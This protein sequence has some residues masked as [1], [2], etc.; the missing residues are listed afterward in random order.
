MSYRPAPPPPLRAWVAHTPSKQ[1]PRFHLLTEHILRVAEM[2]R[3]F[4]EPFQA[5]EIAY[6]LGLLHDLGKFK[7]E[8]QQYL[9]DCYEAAKKGKSGP[10]P[11]TA[12]HKQAGALAAI[13]LLEKGWGELLAIALHGHHSGMKN[14][15]DLLT[16]LR[17]KTNLEEVQALLE[18]AKAVRETLEPLPPTLAPLKSFEGD[19]EGLEMTLR[20]I[21]SCL[22]DADALDTEA[23]NDPQAASLRAAAELPAL[24]EL[25]ETLIRRQEADFL[26]KTGAVNDVRK[27][28]YDACLTAAEQASGFF[29]LT[30]PTG[31]GKTRSSLAFALSHAARHN[32]K[33]VIYAIPYTSIVDQ[34]AGVFRSLFGEETGIV[35]EHHSAIDWRKQQA[36]DKQWQRLTAQ[37]WDA[38]LIVTTTV[39]LFE[40]LFSNRPSACRKLHRLAGS[41]VVL[42]EA[43]CLPLKQMA[44]IRSALK[45]LVDHFGTTVV[46][47]TATQPAHD[48]EAPYLVGLSTRPILAEPERKLQFN[49]LRRVRYR[50]EPE[51][52]DWPQVAAE[53]RRKQNACLCVVNT[54]RQALDLLT[55]L[56][57]DG[58]AE[59]ILH[60]STLLCG[61]HRQETLQAIHRR[62][63]ED[64]RMLLVSTQVIEAGVDLDFPR[65]LRAIGPLERIIQAA[66]RCNREGQ[67][68]RDESEV[69]IF[70]PSDGASPRGHYRMALAKTTQLFEANPEID[71]DDPEFVTAY[72]RKL[73]ADVAIDAKQIG[74]DIQTARQHFR[75]E[76]VAQKMRLIEQDTVSVLTAAYA[77][78]EAQAILSEARSRGQMT[79]A[80]WQRAQPLSVSLFTHDVDKAKAQGHI[81]EIVPGLLLWK[82]SY[83]SK[84]GIPLDQDISDLPPENLVA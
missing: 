31:G 42:D 37:N 43:Q 54:R 20:M 81:E 13:Q 10:L 49:T 27:E 35:L 84:R 28:V 23:H 60:L 70:T 82:G 8:F 17:E 40:S 45:T 64:A 75:Y 83:D 78:E 29:E 51:P 26:G 12:P 6:F 16:A 50:F 68:P 79:R 77:P 34:T 30:V 73:Y 53:M 65:A 72:F 52:W 48:Q 61:R 38:P 11:G 57:P 7:T 58:K 62:L 69:V 63:A 66:G 18:R 56:D 1:N 59:D 2:A 25:L 47:C 67:R 14:Q 33:R 55:L 46:F 80:L 76:E 5:G 71:L 24:Q 41:V 15:K 3:E 74:K 22:V 32:L 36:D 39:Q 21:Y 4:A 19:V 9:I 44:P